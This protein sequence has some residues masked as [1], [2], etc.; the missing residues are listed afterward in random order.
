MKSKK[1]FGALAALGCGAGM[2]HA[3]TAITE[4]TTV[5]GKVFLD[6]TSLDTKTG[7]TKVAPSG[8][9][10]D[11]T[12]FYLS[13]THTFDPIWS[14][15]ITT[16][17]NYSS[18]TGET[19]LFIKKG[20][21]QAKL[22]D[23]FFVRAGSADLPWIPFIEDLYGYRYVE[24]TLT[25]R[26]SFGTSADWGV[27][28]GGKLGD[29]LFGYAASVV[30]GNGYKNPTRSQSPDFEARIAFVP[31]KGLTAGVGFRSGKL[32]N[33]IEGATT[34]HTASR[35]DATIAWVS[36][37]FRLGGEY[38]TA[39]N[40]NKTAITTNV[41]DKADGYSVWG[42]FNFTPVISAFARYDADKPNKDTVPSKKD[43]YYNAGVS[44]KARKN[45]DFSV[46]YK[47]DKVENSTATLTQY[48]EFGVWAQ[49]S[50]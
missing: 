7:D 3:D 42:S 10:V 29:G 11:V 38:F 6:L 40:Y 30:N 39:D 33:D 22:S 46:A 20:Y 47:H 19:Q 41:A 43:T 1:L 2:A 49:A 4:N 27:H 18:S 28:A 9:G 23:A 5:G 8:F 32:G 21:L 35:V 37:Q 25:D 48:D 24:K 36:D 34:Y 44:F 31:V 14:A 17:F 12:R 45:V 13:A 50:F 26:T 16:D 15:N